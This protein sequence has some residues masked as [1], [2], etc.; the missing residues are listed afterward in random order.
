MA[1]EKS[2]VLNSSADK[3]TLKSYSKLVDVVIIAFSICTLLVD[4]ATGEFDAPATSNPSSIASVPLK[5]ADQKKKRW[6]T[7]EAFRAPN[8]PFLVWFQTFLLRMLVIL[9]PDSLAGAAAYVFIHLFGVDS[10]LPRVFVFVV[11]P[12][13]LWHCL[14]VIYTYLG[15][16]VVSC[17][18]VSQDAP[19]PTSS[20]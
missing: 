5:V 13:H 19:E 6:A 1:A 16:R 7:P 15:E 8:T 14:S 4:L 9:H 2:L 12:H 17:E 20:T 18:R 11:S 10:L 3:S